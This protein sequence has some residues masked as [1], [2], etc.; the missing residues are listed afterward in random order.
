MPINVA[1]YDERKTIVL[2][3]FVEPYISTWT[4]YHTAVDEAIDLANSVDHPIGMLFNAQT[5]PMPAGAPLVEMRKATERMP[6]NVSRVVSVVTLNRFE[7]L[8]LGI[9]Q[10]LH[11]K[12][13]PSYTV[14][15]VTQA[16]KLLEEIYAQ[17]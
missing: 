7:A 17:K 11:R 9:F 4:E 5:T 14:S 15:T 8:M 3:D 12:P 10:R 2:L 13:I 6:K 1:W 16:V